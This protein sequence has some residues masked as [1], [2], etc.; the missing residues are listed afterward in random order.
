MST[1]ILVR[2]G[3][4]LLLISGC[5]KGGEKL[6]TVPVTG[7][8]TY[9]GSPVEGATVSLIAKQPDGRGASGTT[10]SQGQFKLETFVGGNN[11]LAG[12]MPGDY[13]VTVRKRE[14]TTELYRNA[15]AGGSAD[16][17]K[18]LEDAAKQEAPP[19]SAGGPPGR[20]G[21]PPNMMMRGRGVDGKSFIP[22]KY[23]NAATSGL[24]AT[25]KPSGNEPLKFELVD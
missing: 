21:P 12:A 14:S 19:A 13:S 5:N 22:E 6:P 7:T 20:G 18:L 17:G 25:V 10:D 15:M 16:G 24:T 1:R 23:E 8:V 9:K 2:L 11:M 4:G 3:A